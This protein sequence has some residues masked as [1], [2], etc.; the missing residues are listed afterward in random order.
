MKNLPALL[1]LLLTV[2]LSLKAFQ[3]DTNS[4]SDKLKKH[5]AVLAADSMEG[6][7]LGTEGKI[8]AKHYIAGEF[9]SAGLQPVGNDYFQHLDLR[10]GLARVPGANVTGYLEG[11]NPELQDEFIILGAHYDH[12]GY[13][14]EN[15]EKVI[16]PGA[17]DNASG[18]AVLI[19]LARY[20]SENRELLGRSVI[21]IAFDAEESGLLGAREFIRD[22]ALFD[23]DKIRLMFSLDMLGMY[24]SNNGLDLNGI[25]TLS[26]GRDLAEAIAEQIGLRLTSTSGDVPPRTDTWPFGEEGIPAIHAFT[27]PESPYHKPE[28]TYDLLDYEG[29]AKISSYLRALVT[30]LSN[31]P[32]LNP[33]RRYARVQRPWGLRFNAGVLAHTGSSY[34]QYTD[35]FFRADNVFAF[36]AGIFLQLHVGEK[37]AFQPEILYD[38]NGSNSEQGT[39]RRHSLTFPLNFQY[40]IAGELRGQIRLY[41][42]AGGY[43]RYNI[44]GK[45]GDQTME[46]NSQHPQ[47]EWGLNLGMGADIMMIHVAYT[48]RRS[49]TDISGQAGSKIH[50]YG[51]YLTIGYK[52]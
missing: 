3:N 45:N 49:L 26:G 9:Q 51:N 12:L 18:T 43:F 13:V 15:G 52:F 39:Y 38:Y 37:F 14:R 8:L 42:I 25:G 40:N 34:H 21:F 1:F 41:P 11:S 30:D 16:F 20:F 31:L 19:E 6:R 2:P 35:E 29:M 5:V 50:Q 46:F 28:D 10:I 33:S 47:Q 24:E 23:A 17:D 48:W 36:S 32:E 27:G 22:N 4:L 7:G 44:S